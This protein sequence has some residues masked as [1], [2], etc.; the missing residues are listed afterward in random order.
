MNDLFLILVL[1]IIIALVGDNR[2]VRSVCALAVLLIVASRKNK[3]ATE[4]PAAEV[5]T[6][7]DEYKKPAIMEYTNETVLNPPLR[8]LNDRMALQEI[9]RGDKARQIHRGMQKNRVNYMKPWFEEE[10]EYNDNV[11]WWNNERL[12]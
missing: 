5:F 3:P 7:V 10:M 1:V 2:L 11:D 6:V 9:Q 8:L 12:R 4:K